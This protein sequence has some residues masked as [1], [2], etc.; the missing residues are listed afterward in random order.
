ML[1]PDVAELL[2]ALRG[3]ER[4]LF[5][6]GI[7]TW[8]ARLKQAADNIEKSDAYGLQQ[9]LSMFGGMGSLNDLILSQDGKLP[10]EENEQLNSLRSK[11]WS[12][13]NNLRR[14]IL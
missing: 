4:L 9:F 3:L 13:A 2:E 14:E 5:E 7:N 11:A 8:A 10:I 6:Q 1:H 12:L